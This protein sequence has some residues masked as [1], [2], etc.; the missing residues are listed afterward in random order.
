M[1]KKRDKKCEGIILSY[2][3]KLYIDMADNPH[4]RPV[5]KDTTVKIKQGKTIID[6]VVTAIRTIT[7]GQQ[8]L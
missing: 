4:I 8:T 5:T 1:S 2:N 6:L 7:N 3:G